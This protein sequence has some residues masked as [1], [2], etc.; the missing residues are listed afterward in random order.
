MVHMLFFNT[1]GRAL[2]SRRGTC[3]R[4]AHNSNFSF[5]CHLCCYSRSL[6]LV[7]AAGAGG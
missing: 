1:F 6:T 4:G 3:A 2:T 5:P 7:W